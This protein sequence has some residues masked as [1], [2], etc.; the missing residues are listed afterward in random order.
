MQQVGIKAFRANLSRWMA[1]VKSGEELV[2]TERGRPVARVTGADTMARLDYLR[3]QGVVTAA[4]RPKTPIR[5]ED[6]VK[7]KGSVSELVKEQ[8]R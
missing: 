7:A 2:I 1:V 4:K 5:R 3:A 8:R 6:L